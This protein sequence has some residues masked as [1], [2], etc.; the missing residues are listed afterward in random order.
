MINGGG[1]GGGGSNASPITGHGD[2]Q[3]CEMLMIPHFLGSPLS[4]GSRVVSF[5]CQQQFT[6]QEDFWYTFLLEADPTLGPQ[7]SWNVYVN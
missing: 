2:L 4:D 7:C 3:G 6:P 1:G 5:T